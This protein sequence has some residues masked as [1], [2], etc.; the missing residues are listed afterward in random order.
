MNKINKEKRNYLILFLSVILIVFLTTRFQYK[1]GSNTDWINQHTVIPEYFRNLF[2]DTGKLLPNLALSYGGGQ[3]IFNLSYYGLLSPLILP[4]YLLPFVSMEKYMVVTN[5]MNLVITA[6]LFYKWLKNH[7]CNDTVCLI[8]SLLFILAPP[9]IFH[10]HRHIMFVNYMPFLV[11]SLMGVDKL[12]EKNDRPLLILSIFLMIMTSYYYSVCGIIVVSLYYLYRYIDSKDKVNFK[13]L[14]LDGLKYV[15]YVFIAVFMSGIL[16]LPTAYTLTSG[17]NEAVSQ[18]SLLK[19]FTPYLKIYKLFCGTYSIGISMIGFVALLYLFY[20][21][22]KSN[23]V[24]ATSSSVVIGLPLFM[25]I[26]N[27]GLYL[28]EKCFIPFIPLFA[29]IIAIFIDNLLK[30][31][32]DTKK[33]A[34][35]VSLISIPMYYYNQRQLCYVYLLGLIIILALYK[36]KKYMKN[37]FISLILLVAFI[38]TGYE[39]VKEQLEDEAVSNTM[40][41]EIFSDNIENEI[42][43]ALNNDS[44]FYRSNNLIYP[45]KT[46]NKI[47]NNNYYTTTIYSSTYNYNY[48]DFV[49]HT[50]KTSMLEYNYFLVPASNNILFNSLMGV[51]YS[52]SNYDLGMGYTKI[53]DNTYINNLVLPIIYESNNIINEKEFANY[54]YPYQTELLLKNVVTKSSTKNKKDSTITKEDIDYV[55]LENDGVEIENT[56]NSYTLTVKDKGYLKIKLTNALKNKFL[57]INLY[58]LQENSC[59]TG[60]NISIK[61]NNVENILT[62]KTWGYDNKNNDFKYVIS[63]NN[64]EYLDIELNKGTFNIDKIETYTLD[65]NDIKDINENI[66]GIEIT[67]IENDSIKG[68]INIKNNDSYLVTSIPYDKGYKVLIDNKLTS[69]EEVNEGFIGLPI[70]KGEHKIEIKYT[71]PYLNIGKILSIIGTI[72]FVV[73]LI[74]DIKKKKSITN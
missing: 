9:L 41:N 72:S 35:F 51:K 46:V 11:M 27:G 13:D 22:K 61:I 3:N 33:F 58:G 26:L 17:R 69:H 38:T 59:K 55:L 68:T 64:I 12:I 71:S 15:F 6:I 43:K 70:T 65:Y 31:K 34:I 48:L 32:V 63:N 2:Y 39:A 14:I 53:D 23:I 57:F 52:F 4:S 7:K 24:L 40:Y 5:I 74:I 21:K 60:D 1:F 30:D 29:Y 19:L 50:Y 37:I 73:I 44:S 49:R 20:T 10:M 25:Y 66:N 47:Y 16:L 62:C 8:T 36:K 18:I 42:K 67:S 45:T 56:D 28:R 54:D